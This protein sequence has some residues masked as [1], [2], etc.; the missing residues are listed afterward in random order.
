MEKERNQLKLLLT[1]VNI[2]IIGV[3]AYLFI[4]FLLPSLLP[5]ICAFILVTITK[6]LNDF[7]V[8]KLSVSKKIVGAMITVILVSLLSIIIYF[9]LSR[10]IREIATFTSFLA[11]GGMSDILKLLS[12]KTVGFL[13][14]LLP[15]DSAEKLAGTIS[16]K[17]MNADKLLLRI[18]SDFYPKI[19][20]A[21]MKFLSFFP[22][23]V[24]FT[25]LLFISTF[26]IGCD[27]ENIVSFINAQFTGKGLNNFLSVKKQLFSTVK[28]LF[29]A[30]LFLTI[31]TFS[32]LLTGFIILKV[33][34]AILLALLISFI[35]MLPILG[36]GT[37]LVPW[38]IISLILGDNTKAIGLLVL[39][40]IIT[41]FRQILEPR[42]VGSSLGLSPLVTLISMYAG[43]KLVGFWGLFIFPVCTIFIKSLNDRGIIHLYKVPEKTDYEQI[44]NVRKKY[45]SI[46]KNSK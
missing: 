5:F 32:E 17:I 1:F 37:V 23:A 24:I 29:R 40:G 44:E 13:N 3:A 28:D 39:Y 8:R 18:S 10:L 12:E 35:D 16:E 34:Y 2:T 30:Y 21:L 38:S 43:I 22:Q 46:R 11:D 15:E 7:L 27:Y 14:K 20:E 33:N 6:P 9:S 19:I 26:Y 36:T 45:E 4:K 31:I 42:I 25:V 41:V